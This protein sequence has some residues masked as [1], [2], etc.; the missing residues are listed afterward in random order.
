M[1]MY[2]RAIEFWNVSELNSSAVSIFIYGVYCLEGFI[3][4]V[5]NLIFSIHT[6]KENT[7]HLRV[8]VHFHK[9]RQLYTGFGNERY[10]IW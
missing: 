8:S 3:A 9:L 4:V 6:L 2:E 5:T 10:I 1:R 7:M